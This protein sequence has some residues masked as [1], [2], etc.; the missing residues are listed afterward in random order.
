[1]L[2]WK[3]FLESK[4]DLPKDIE[5]ARKEP[6]GSDVGKERKTSG[7]TKGPF[8][9][10]S[11]GAPKGSYPVTSAKQGKSAKRLAHNAPNPKGI[12]KCVDRII[13]KKKE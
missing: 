13:G 6:G 8:C 5:K 11:G 7:P 3:Q 2:T 4:S 1:M 10:P 12:A 9:G